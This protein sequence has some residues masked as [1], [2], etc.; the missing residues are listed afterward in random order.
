MLQTSLI[1]EAAAAA[2]LLTDGK[3]EARSLKDSPGAPW[4]VTCPSWGGPLAWFSDH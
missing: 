2:A 1:S 4:L 3:T